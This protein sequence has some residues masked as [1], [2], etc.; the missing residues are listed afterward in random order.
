VRIGKLIISDIL[1]A[2]KIVVNLRVASVD[3]VAADESI[4]KII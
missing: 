4:V 3:F 2:V 1:I